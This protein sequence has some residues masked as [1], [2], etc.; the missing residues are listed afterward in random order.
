MHKLLILPQYFYRRQFQHQLLRIPK[1][2]YNRFTMRN[3]TSDSQSQTCNLK[4]KNNLADRFEGNAI[5]RSLPAKY[6]AGM[7]S[8]GNENEIIL[9]LDIK[10]NHCNDSDKMINFQMNRRIDKDQSPLPLLRRMETTA[11]KHLKKLDK[12]LSKHSKKRRETHREEV[13]GDHK[14]SDRE[15]MVSIQMIDSDTILTS[16]ELHRFNAYDLWSNASRISLPT[17]NIELNVIYNPPTLVKSP[18]MLSNFGQEIFVGV[19]LALGDYELKFADYA[20]IIWKI[21]GRVR[22]E[23]FGEIYHSLSSLTPQS[24]DIGKHVSVTIIPRRHDFDQRL[25]IQAERLCKVEFIFEH[26]VKIL[27][28]MPILHPL[29]SEWTKKRDTC[30]R[31][32]LIRIMTYNI[33]A[34]LY[35]RMESIHLYGHVSK[36]YLRKE[37][38]LVSKYY[39]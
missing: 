5:I 25:G 31:H 3:M 35:V 14:N 21:D 17:L 36:E 20:N 26:V 16:Q 39:A 27:P 38:R 30:S 18:L 2:R 9:T 1:A 33:L 29:R 28:D 13:S 15:L 34:S 7:V 19:P 32:N 12:S 11:M 22:E 4:F 6:V 23:G 24:T 10:C 8:N 37:W